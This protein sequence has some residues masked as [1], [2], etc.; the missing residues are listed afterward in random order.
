VTDKQF[1]H[2]AAVLATVATRYITSVFIHLLVS[3]HRAPCGHPGIRCLGQGIGLGLAPYADAALERQ[4]LLNACTETEHVFITT[5]G[6][7]PF[8]PECA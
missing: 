1:D 8:L 5:I 4:R 6:D 3:S 2:S 7:Y